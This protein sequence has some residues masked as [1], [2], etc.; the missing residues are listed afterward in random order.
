MKKRV[1]S[2]FLAIT[3]CL[4]LT[5]TGALAEK[6]QP[7]QTVAA[8]QE[9]ETPTP[10][11]QKEESTAPAENGADENASP[12][13]PDE[14]PTENTPAAAEK[15]PADEEPGKEPAAATGKDE[16]KADGSPS[17]D[18]AAKVQNRLVMA[19]AAEPGEPTMMGQNNL[20]ALADEEQ[21]AAEGENGEAGGTPC[22][23]GGAEGFD[24][25]ATTCP[26]CGVAA[27]AETG[28]SNGQ[29]KRFADLQTAIDAERDGVAE[30]RLLTDV[31]G[32][33]TINGTQ[34]TGLDLNG[35]SIK[36]TVTV[37]GIKD[38]FITT[39]LSNTKNTTTASI[40]KVVACDGAELAGSGYPAVI[41]ELTLAEGAT[42]NNILNGTALGYKVLKADGTHKWYAPNDVNDS[43]LNNVIINSL[44]ITSNTLY[45]KKVDGKNL[46]GSSPKV[47][48]GTT[49]QLCA[50]CNANGADVYIYTGE[51]VGNNE[52]T[53]SPKKAEYK[54]IG[55]SWYYVVDLNANTIGTYDIYFTASKDGYKVTSAHKTLK[56]TKATI[57]TSAITAPTAQEN[58]TYTGQEQALI[59]AGSVTDYGTMQ[60]SL[61]KNGRY[62]QNIPTG[63]D[64]GKYTVWYR[65]FGDANHK[66]TAPASVVVSI[67]KK[68]L[69]IPEVTVA[70]KTYDGTTNA[71]I[72]D[73]TFDNVTLNR[74]TDYTVTASFDDAGVGSGKNVTATVTLM[75]QAAKN[76]ALEQSSFPTTGSITKAAAPDF[77]KETALD[78]ANDYAN[79]YTVALPALPTLKTP[80]EYG[81]LT[82]EIGGIKLNGGYY[83]SGAKV[84]NGELTLPIQKNDVETTGSVGTVTV[85]IKSANYEDI[86]LTVNV[87][88]KNRITP[89]GTPTLSKNAITYGDALNTIALSGKLHDDVNNVDVDGTFEWVDGTF[90]PAANDSYQAGWKF[91]PTNQEKYA[92]VTGT[93]T[94]KVNKAATTG[95]PSYTKITTGNRTLKDAAL[96]IGGSTLN[97]DDGKLEWVDDEGNVLPDDTRVTANTTYKWRFTPTDT[98]YT[99]LTGEIELYHRS[100]GGGGSSGYSYYSIK[101]TAGTGG[102]ISPS[103][104]VSVREGAD[105]IFTIT[106]DKGYAVSNVKI[107]GRSIGAVKSYTF[108]NVKRAHTIEVSFTR[109]NEFVDV[110]TS[111]YFYE[112]VMWAVENG[113]TTGV[114][115]SCFDPNGVCTRAQ[116]VAFLWRAAGSPAPRSRTMP[117]TDVLVGSYYYD[118]VL[119][120]VETG[121]TKG[122]SGTTFSPNAT[123]SRAQIVAFLWRSQKSPAAGT[124]NPFADVKSTA[125][126]AGAV[127]WALRENITKGTTSTTFSPDADCTRA[128]IVSFLW[129]CKK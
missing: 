122:T 68:P 127:L 64:A 126:Y 92:E 83:T 36:G 109:A 47:E 10:A 94:I 120:A 50:S 59:T 71:D 74:G 113:V 43:Q 32:E 112:A 114:N 69:P 48:R 128:Q 85:V 103:G 110:P 39:T 3:L 102:A 81:A 73:V 67:G 21:N 106:P 19:A 97:P 95:A 58:L 34:N 46:T 129:R 105:Q 35:H 24:I 23:H 45:L 107:D 93:V 124:A 91:T 87:S 116:A 42:W 6:S 78:I 108:E 44:P 11:P 37:K 55:T 66:D 16:S 9:T 15:N 1:L 29:W 4:S 31:T 86:T 40:D 119:W 63:T 53:Y 100:G 57:P 8:T 84:E 60:Y 61:T 27:V 38:D 28:L 98:N 62:S 99:A 33:Y 25:S 96:T 41:G 22:D 79:T 65:V 115:A 111:S 2:L 18:D 77:T 51:I 54:K 104:N 13:S 82:Y 76:Y 20:L 89:T 56:V 70:S 7:E 88:A 5:P 30:F 26:D 121:I 125:Y 14:K 12:A 52:P 118:A 75:G 80:K 101:A 117:F 49:V 90:K 123:C 72:T 17:D